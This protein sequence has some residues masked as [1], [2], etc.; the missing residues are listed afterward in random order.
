MF[1]IYR[2][3]KVCVVLF[4]GTENTVRGTGFGDRIVCCV[5]VIPGSNYSSREKSLRHFAVR[6][7]MSW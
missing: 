6:I 3:K 7:G 4:S 1:L 2:T 5:S